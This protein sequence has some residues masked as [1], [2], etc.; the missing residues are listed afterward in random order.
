[1]PAGAGARAGGA[2]GP[3]RLPADLLIVVARTSSLGM[4]MFLV[5]RGTPEVG[6]GGGITGRVS[7]GAVTTTERPPVARQE[8]MSEPLRVRSP[9]SSTITSWI[10]SACRCRAFRR[11]MP[12]VTLEP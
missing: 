1:M 3:A 12:M 10:D 9:R 7:G 2:G 8:V 6:G 11:V 4:T 5:P